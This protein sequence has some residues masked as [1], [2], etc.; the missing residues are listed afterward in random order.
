MIFC[1]D[2]LSRILG[3]SE[4]H[5]PTLL[6]GVYSYNQAKL[7]KNGV[8]VIEFKLKND[9]LF[10]E[11]RAGGRSDHR[12][13]LTASAREFLGLPGTIRRHSACR[14]CRRLRPGLYA[15]TKKM[16]GRA[17]GAAGRVRGDAS[18]HYCEPKMTR[19]VVRPRSD[20]AR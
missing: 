18:W 17:C 16:V 3:Y 10:D 8:K 15:R 20:D 14:S 13:F 5:I 1:F 6:A 12:S 9:V 19:S 2:E 7:E 4:F 11:I